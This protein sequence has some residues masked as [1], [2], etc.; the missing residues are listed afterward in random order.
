[1]LS[2]SEGSEEKSEAEKRLQLRR[3]LLE[4]MESSAVGQR[5]FWSKVKKKGPDDC[6]EWVGSRQEGYGAMLVSG[7]NFRA[8]RISYFF[9]HRNLPED[10][11]VCHRCD[12]PACV[13]PDHLFL[14]TAIENRKDCVQKVRHARGEG[15]H[16][17]KLIE[18]EV[19]EIRSLNF[20]TGLSYEKLAIRFK[21]SKQ[22]IYRVINRFSWKHIPFPKGH[23]IK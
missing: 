1:M 10:L 17:H 20:L 23:R 8:H 15:Q 14:G 22:T 6:W 21:V 12:N 5:R 4:K 9:K 19:T 13:N 3:K 7:F 16:K 2:P 11:C 18:S